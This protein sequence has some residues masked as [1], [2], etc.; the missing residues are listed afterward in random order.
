[1]IQKI[2]NSR[3]KLLIDLPNSLPVKGEEEGG[4]GVTGFACTIPVRTTCFRLRYSTYPFWKK[5]RN[6]ASRHSSGWTRKKRL[7][8]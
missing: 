1:M 7:P 6:P 8:M 4:C 3:K 2:I 5:L